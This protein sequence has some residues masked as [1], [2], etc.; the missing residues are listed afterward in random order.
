MAHIPFDVPADDE[1]A[2]QTPEQLQALIDN[3]KAA[4][5]EYAQMNIDDASSEDAAS[6]REL[7]RVIRF[8]RKAQGNRSREEDVA[9]AYAALADALGEGDEDE[10]AGESVEDAEEAESNRPPVKPKTAAAPAVKPKAPS[11]TAAAVGAAVPAVPDERDSGEGELK[12]TLVAAAGAPGLVAG[13]EVSWLDVAKAVERNLIAYQ[14]LGPNAPLVQQGVAVLN[15]PYPDDLVA[16]AGPETVSDDF[17]AHVADERR[18]PGG[19]LLRSIELAEKRALARGASVEAAALTAA[20]TGWCAPSTTLYDLFALESND[21]MLDIPEMNVVR[22]GIKYTQ[23]PDFRSIWGGA[24]FFDYTEAQ[25]ITGVTKPVM[26]AACPAFTDTRLDAVGTAIQAD[27]LTL[28]GYPELTSRFVQGAMVAHNHRVNAKVI[29]AIVTGSTTIPQTVTATSAW[30]VDLS[31]LNL[32]LAT[33]SLA[34]TDYKYGNRMR[35]DATIEVVA[36]FWALSMLQTDL[37]RRA[38]VDGDETPQFAATVA[39]INR[40]AAARGAR[41]QWVYDWQDAFYWGLYASGASPAHT[42]F[43]SDPTS[44]ANVVNEWNSNFNILVYAAGTWIRGNADVITLD[45]VYDSTLLAQNKATQLFQEQGIL[46]AKRG[47]DS[48][49]YK[50]GNSK[51]NAVGTTFA[52]VTFA[53]P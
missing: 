31:I 11:V 40:F 29:N 7:A 22:G 39:T 38:F 26:A 52:P 53:G 35:K 18:L 36:P 34:I 2:S 51:S 16:S 49:I 12:A 44:G 5:A 23:G 20:G 33:L 24:G 9:G 1:F 4:A 46:V 32:F 15:I 28:R 41:V 3:A 47:F 19:S 27:L 10:S 48:R 37:E 21:G 43:G 42:Q 8:A 17:L 6:M 13:A 25:I 50:V 45:T 14:G 30:L